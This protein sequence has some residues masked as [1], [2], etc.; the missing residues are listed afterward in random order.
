[1]T[2]VTFFIVGVMRVKPRR[3]VANLVAN[4]SRAMSTSGIR[5]GWLG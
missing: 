4:D 2:T 5:V 3:A 1:M